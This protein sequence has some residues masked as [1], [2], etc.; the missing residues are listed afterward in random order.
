MFDSSKLL[1]KELE[2]YKINIVHTE[3]ISSQRIYKP[4][5]T[6]ANGGVSKL[7]STQLW[8]G[9]GLALSRFNIPVSGFGEKTEHS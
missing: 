5:K 3:R 2:L 1:I 6:A 7:V 9:S 8:W 4:H